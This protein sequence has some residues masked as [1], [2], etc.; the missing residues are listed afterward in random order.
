[1]SSL[2]FL[3]NQNHDKKQNIDKL[4]VQQGRSIRVIFSVEYEP[5][6]ENIPSRQFFF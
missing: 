2:K 1:M 4:Y 6:I 3:S 5:K